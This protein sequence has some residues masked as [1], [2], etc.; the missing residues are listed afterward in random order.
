LT[1]HQFTPLRLRGLSLRNR[2]V[3]SPMCQYQAV[4]GLVQDWHYQHHARFALGGVGA[5]FVEATGVTRDGRITHG[6]TGLWD[7][8]QIPGLARIAELY[9]SHGVSPGIQLGHAGR[10]ASAARP[11]EGAAP[12]ANGGP[13]P[14][15]ET[16]GASAV[17]EREGYPVPRPLTVAEIERI[18]DAFRAAVRRARRAGF[19]IVEIHGAHGYLIH[20]FFSPLA[21]RREDDFGGMREKR[22]RLPLLIAE[23]VR[24]EWPAELPVFYRASCVDGIEGGVTIDDTVA[25][26]IELKARGVDLIDC[27][28]G[29]MSGPAT[30]STRKITQGYQVPYAEAVR[31]GTDLP[32]MA[33]GAIIDPTLAE[34]ILAEGRAD[35]IALGRELL[36]DPNWAYRAARELGLEQPWRVLPDQ[37]AFYLERR[38]AVLE[39]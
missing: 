3:V 34:A 9:R 29:G 16:V 33:V 22:M 13:D 6:C 15:W 10:R 39:D 19:D 12:L 26:A 25:L 17:A 24:A 32:T 23:A 36:A 30:L 1:P 18:V 38:A 4:E 14:A 27:S 2:I 7:D 5:A 35:L 37:Y 11:W 8:G 28:S 21:N 31:Q 20:S